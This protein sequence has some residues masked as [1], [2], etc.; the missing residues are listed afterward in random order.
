MNASEKVGADGAHPAHPRPVRARHPG[1]RARHAARH[2]HL[3]AHARARPRRD[4][5]ARAPRGGPA[6]PQGDRGLPGR[7]ASSRLRPP[8]VAGEGASRERRPPL[9]PATCVVHY[10]AIQALRGISLEVP[11]GQIVALIGANGAGKTTTLRAIS[12][13]RPPGLRL[14]RVPGADVAGLASHEIVAQ[15][16][17]HAPEGRGIFLNLT[18]KENLDL[19]AYLRRD[20]A[21]VDADRERAYALFPILE[22]AQRPGGGHALRRRA[23]DAGGGPRADEPAHAAAPRRA[24]ARPRAAGRGADLPIIRE[25]NEAGVSLL[26]VEQNAHMALAARAPRLRAGDRRRGDAGQRAG[27][28]RESPRSARPTSGSE[29]RRSVPACA[30]ARGCASSLGAL[31]LAA[32]TAEEGEARVAAA[33]APRAEGTP[34]AWNGGRAAVTP[35]VAGSVGRGG[36]RNQGAVRRQLRPRAARK[37]PGRASR[38]ARPRGHSNEPARESPLAGPHQASVSGSPSAPAADSRRGVAPRRAARRARRAPGP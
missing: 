37:T 9:D 38:R 4:H 35:E 3:R 13:A 21:G 11:K 31:V 28:A 12:G 27:A 29:R 33:E 1:D 24:V 22:G 26:L 10:G 16:M 34:S 2:G 36:G 17:A 5:R 25:I 20:R 14:R 19:G 6:R 15:G 32:R 18:V 7:R 23:A 30:G 8:R